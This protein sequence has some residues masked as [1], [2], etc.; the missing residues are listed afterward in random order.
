MYHI[1][2]SDYTYFAIHNGKLWVHPKIQYLFIDLGIDWSFTKYL[3]IY[4]FCVAQ[5]QAF[6]I[7]KVIQ[8]ASL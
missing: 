5:M 3:F 8:M 6:T 4:L 1:L 7:N 2:F